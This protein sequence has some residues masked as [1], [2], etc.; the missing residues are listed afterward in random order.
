MTEQNLMKEKP[1]TDL[2]YEVPERQPIKDD[3]EEIEPHLNPS[4]SRQNLTVIKGIGS[5]VEKQLYEIN[6]MT[7]NDL[8]TTIPE[9]LSFLKGIGL[10]KAQKIIEEAKSH[11]RTKNLNEFS[12]SFDTVRI[13]NVKEEVMQTAPLTQDVIDHNILEPE[14]VEVQE[15]ESENILEDFLID[16]ETAPGLG[17]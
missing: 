17:L 11:L 5:S 7:V 9:K 16:P 3:S 14:I 12:D 15:Y 4:I 6:I 8:A 1:N 10:P 13:E 2:N